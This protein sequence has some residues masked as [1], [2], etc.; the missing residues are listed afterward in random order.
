MSDKPI[1]TT[2]PESE[3]RLVATAILDPA[4]LEELEREF[5]STL[6]SHPPAQAVFATALKMRKAGEPVDPATVGT[7]IRHQQEG[8]FM[9]ECVTVIIAEPIR[10]SFEHY[11]DRVRDS[12]GRRVVISKGQALVAAAADPFNKQWQDLARGIAAGVPGAEPPAFA[13]G[14]RNASEIWT[15]DP[16]LITGMSSPWLILNL[17]RVGELVLMSGGAKTW[18][19]WIAYHIAFC[20]SK[21]LRVF[22][23]YGTIG[24]VRVGYLDYE[25]TDSQ[26]DKRLCLSADE[27]PANLKVCSLAVKGQ[28]RIED[29]KATI[30]DNGFGLI[31][32][33]CLYATGWLTDENDN[34]LVAEALRKL[35]RI[36]IE[37]GCTI[38]IV[39]H[40]GKGGGRDKSVADAARGASSKGGVPDVV[41][42]TL[43]HLEDSQDH[44]VTIKPI[45]RD[46]P[47]VDP[48]VTQ[49]SWT[50]TSF[51]LRVTDLTYNPV[52][53]GQ[54]AEEILNHIIDVEESTYALMTETLGHTRK[55]LETPLEVL[56]ARKQITRETSPTDKRKKIFRP[57]EALVGGLSLT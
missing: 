56:I 46:A 45:L 25:L 40:T 31:V 39:D 12:I 26:Q 37:T 13:F 43:P 20:T 7:A 55:Q 29:L 27:V 42:Q 41:I 54:I 48:I 24:E 17:I 5:P 10:D 33:D 52:K 18:K 16:D 1:R 35:R 15:K 34:L 57:A 50:E 36:A 14:W 8:D 6:F 9:H 23:K 53:S 44:Y 49:V 2:D 47:P 28:P 3:S 30:E 4:R 22:G 21:Q 11:T 19:T 51:N 38:I 32:I